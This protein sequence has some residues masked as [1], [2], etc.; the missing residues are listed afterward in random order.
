MV[1]IEPAET[2]GVYFIG[3]QQPIQLSVSVIFIHCVDQADGGSFGDLDMPSGMGECTSAKMIS[4]CLA[5]ALRSFFGI[6]FMVV[7]VEDK[8]PLYRLLSRFIY[9]L[10]GFP[11]R[12]LSA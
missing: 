8:A 2:V 7:L 10:S 11:S 5:A 12:D 4:A 9:L 6:V 1:G 3:F